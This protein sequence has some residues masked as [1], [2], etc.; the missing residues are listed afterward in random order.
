MLETTNL[1][2]ALFLL[3]AAHYVFNL[4]YHTKAAEVLTFIQEKFAK[5]PTVVF[6]SKHKGKRPK[7]KSPVASSHI[8]GIV[9]CYE[10]L[11]EECIGADHDID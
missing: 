2:S 1:A 4:S 10:S 11:K 6:D 3:L 5:I 8:I 7:D 9:R